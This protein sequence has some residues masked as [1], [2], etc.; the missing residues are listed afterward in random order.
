MEV[1]KKNS[2]GTY[3]KLS[4]VVDISQ[5]N[6]VVFDIYFRKLAGLSEKIIFMFV[7][8]VVS[9]TLGVMLYVGKLEHYLIWCIGCVALVVFFSYCKD[10]LK[11]KKDS[12]SGVEKYNDVIKNSEIHDDINW[13]L[14]INKESFENDC[15]YS[16]IDIFLS[17]QTRDFPEEYW[18]KEIDLYN[19]ILFTQKSMLVKALKV[20]KFVRRL[21]ANHF[22][23]QVNNRLR[24]ICIYHDIY[25]GKWF[26]L[27]EKR[28]LEERYG[29]IFDKISQEVEDARIYDFF[30]TINKND[31]KEEI[32]HKDRCYEEMDRINNFMQ[33][34]PNM[35]RELDLKK[36]LSEKDIEVRV[37]KKI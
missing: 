10:F 2:E 4:D 7:S 22:L 1:I 26:I 15:P 35:K 3:V 9:V 32:A 6:N 31:E 11:I 17:N 28:I 16:I 12:L 27:V 24:N 30:V 5:V 23:E 13:N 29:E 18:R 34:L 33:A 37:K 21:L 19:Q 8:G 25:E 20:F 14:L 36:K